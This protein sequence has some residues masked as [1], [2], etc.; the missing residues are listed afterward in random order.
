MHCKTSWGTRTPVVVLLLQGTSKVN[1]VLIQDVSDHVASFIN[2]DLCLALEGTH[3]A[4]WLVLITTT[5]IITRT[6]VTLILIM[7]L[8]TTKVVIVVIMITT[9]VTIVVT[10]LI[11]R[12]TIN[13][14]LSS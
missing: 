8:T 12:I 4:S 10:L 11:V 6:I 3:T 13:T 5:L 14:L 9:M 2:K 7:I 1:Q